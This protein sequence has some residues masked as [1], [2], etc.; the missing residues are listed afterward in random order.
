MDNFY[1]DLQILENWYNNSII[2]LEEYFKIKSSIVDFYLKHK[3]N[4]EGDLPF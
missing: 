4:E 3:E 1:R 2:N